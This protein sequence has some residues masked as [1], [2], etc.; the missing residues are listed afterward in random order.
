M[1]AESYYSSGED[2]DEDAIFGRGYSFERER[3]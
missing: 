2:E 1:G 3:D